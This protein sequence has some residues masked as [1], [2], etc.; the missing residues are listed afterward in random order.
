LC[1]R[2]VVYECR[3]CS[4]IITLGKQFYKIPEVASPTAI[5]LISTKK[6]SKFISHTRKFVFFVIHAHSKQ[7][8]VAISMA[9]IKSLSLQ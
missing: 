9:S 1:K 4:V 6:C 3:P 7:E 2:H 5:S 8:V